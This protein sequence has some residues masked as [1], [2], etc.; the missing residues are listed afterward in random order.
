M[1]QR[2]CVF[3]GSNE[4][5][6][7]A[8]LAAAVR[9]GRLL[10]SE[11]IELV[12]GGG[13]VGLMGAVADACLADGGLVIGVIPRFLMD[14]ELGHQG[15]TEL[16][17]VESM[18]ERKA[19]MADLSDGFAALPGG[20]G[21]ME[22]LFEVWTWGQLG[23]HDKPVGL[24][25]VDGYFDPLRAFIDHMVEERFLH[26]EHRAM[27]RVETDPA[28]LIDQLRAWRPVAQ[29]KWLDGGER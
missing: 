29:S 8:Y 7:P 20:I 22:E 23:N 27:L 4:G 3:T 12:Y 28:L 11:G 16:R 19:L 25:N 13:R 6:S 17:I 21:T 2:L 10:A 1:M 24:L 15:V 14:L 5:K 18:H 26:G 9:M